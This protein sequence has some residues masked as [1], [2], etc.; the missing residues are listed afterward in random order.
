MELTGIRTKTDEKPKDFSLMD[1]IQEVIDGASSP[2]SAK[3]ISDAIA[4]KTGYDPTG[5]N[6]RATGKY[7]VTKDRIAYDDAAKTFLK[8]NP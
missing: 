7:M 5:K 6:V 1:E 2:M 8:K 3:Q 4:E